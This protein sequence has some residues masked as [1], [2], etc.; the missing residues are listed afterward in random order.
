MLRIVKK[1][2]LLIQIEY[3]SIV[4]LNQLQLTCFINEK[5]CVVQLVLNSIYYQLHVL[6]I[7]EHISSTLTKLI[8]YVWVHCTYWFTWNKH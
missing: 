5:N 8:V 1:V 4:S 6:Y 3:A 7:W 2:I